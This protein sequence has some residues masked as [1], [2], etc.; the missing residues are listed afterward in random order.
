[1]GKSIDCPN[2]GQAVQTYRNPVPTV[3]IILHVPEHGV[4]LIKRKNPPYGWALPGGFVDY[5]ESL[6]QAAVRELKEETG[7]QAELELLL[8][9]YSHPARDPRQHNLSVVFVAG[10][11]D[12][13]SMQPGDD[14]RETQFF[15]CGHWPE[16]VFDHARILE[17]FEKWLQGDYTADHPVQNGSSVCLGSKNE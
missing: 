13:K 11:K 6:E 7:L 12:L 4:L 1:M 15:V 10:A 2:C 5:G 17:D 14:A 8:G 16:L 3:D 9:V